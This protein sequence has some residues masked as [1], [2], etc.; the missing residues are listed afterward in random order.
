MMVPILGRLVIY[1]GKIDVMADFYCR[2]FDF[3]LLRSET[4]RI[5]ELSPKSSG[6][7]ILLHPSAAKQREGQVLV[8]LVFDVEDVPAFCA[9]AK[10]KGLEFG[11]V[12][13]ADG[14][15]FA[16]AKDPAKNSI[17]VSS[18]AFRKR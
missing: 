12:H 11:K 15:C 13:E 8:K 16:N 5:V 6:M 4:D 18:R 1:T 14:Y 17:Q 2:F 9:A 7:T 10:A 3:S